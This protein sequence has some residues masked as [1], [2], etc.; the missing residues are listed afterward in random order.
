M[1]N[2]VALYRYDDYGAYFSQGR[3]LVYSLQFLDS[4]SSSPETNSD[5][6]YRSEG[7][8][9]DP[10]LYPGLDYFVEAFDAH[11]YSDWI[12]NRKLGYFRRPLSL[13]LYVPFCWPLCLYCHSN[14]I[15]SP[16]KDSIETYVD[17]LLRNIRLQGQLFSGDTK[18]EQIYFRGGTTFLSD[19]QL[20]ALTEEIKQ[21]FNLIEGG[22]FCIEIAAR[23]LTNCSMQVL[24]K[25]GFNSAVVG[26]HDL[27]QQTNHSKQRIQ[28]EKTIVQA[29]CDIRRAGF[30]SVRVEFNYG[31][32]RQNLDETAN[33]LLKIIA[34]N[35]NQIRLSNYKQC[36]G[37]LKLQR[38]SSFTKS[39]ETEAKF[40]MMLLA[41]SCLTEAGYSH[42]GMNLFA[43][44]DD[45]LAVAQR[46]G[47]LHYGVRGFS[48]YPDCDHLALG[49][50][51]VS[52]IG[53][54]LHQNQ[55]DLL[56]YYDKL[57]KNIPPIFR[58]LGLSA[59]DLLRRSIMYALICHSVISYDAVEAFFPINF[60]QYFVT[61]LA[62]LQAYVEAGLVAL[63]NEEI[64]VTP[65]GQL[66]I[67]SICGVFDKYLRKQH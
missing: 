40:E 5:L 30:N 42:I 9:S 36:A 37:I 51:G 57:E 64:V 60:K 20:R 11:T 25:I 58:G 55:C 47:R 41:I 44:Y 45:P 48:T 27:D 54:T 28:S 24:N 16:D 39:P 33:S 34:T 43:R 32:P 21:Y 1:D 66:F 35:P 49:A 12:N 26:I 53:P 10:C 19:T 38:N 46:Q 14:Q 50:S 62:D 67:N 6:I 56:Q 65:K 31:L 63:D 7:C 3:K 4:F 23:P 8:Y 13:E 59:D 18:I 2:T 22:D 29:I 61:E 52:R 15:F 17:Y